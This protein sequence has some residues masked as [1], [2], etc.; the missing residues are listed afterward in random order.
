[1]RVG[2]GLGSICTRIKPIARKINESIKLNLY[3]CILFIKSPL[4]LFYHY[5]EIGGNGGYL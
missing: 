3:F 1:M 5:F 4:T 2:R